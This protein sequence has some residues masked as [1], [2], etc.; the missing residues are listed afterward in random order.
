MLSSWKRMALC[1]EGF[2]NNYIASF[3]TKNSKTICGFSFPEHTTSTLLRLHCNLPPS[4]LLRHLSVLAPLQVVELTPDKC[5]VLNSVPAI[6]VRF[7]SFRSK[8][9]FI[10]KKVFPLKMIFVAF[11]GNENSTFLVKLLA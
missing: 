10:N 4:S 2:K 11:G 8:Y 6:S 3:M 7:F 1:F 9:F 5:A